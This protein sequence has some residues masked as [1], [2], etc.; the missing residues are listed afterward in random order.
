MAALSLRSSE[1]ACTAIR[2]EGGRPGRGL[3]ETRTRPQ[4]LYR[5]LY[6]R[7]GTL[8]LQGA[9]QQGQN[10]GEPHYRGGEG[11]RAGEVTGTHG[12][13]LSTV[14]FIPA[15]GQGHQGGWGSHNPSFIFGSVNPAHAHLSLPWWLSH[16]SHAYRGSVLCSSPVPSPYLSQSG[17]QPPSPPGSTPARQR[18][19]FQKPPE[20]PLSVPSSLNSARDAG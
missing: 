18:C 19:V 14:S 17:Q 1:S 6:P 5:H 3:W 7:E 4:T 2:T 20:Y 9:S 13:S 15:A 12:P 11:G 10:E 8:S 16:S